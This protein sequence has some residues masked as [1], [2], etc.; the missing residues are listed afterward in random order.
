VRAS[1][2]DRHT[3]EQLVHVLQVDNGDL[4][5]RL[6]Q[7]EDHLAVQEEEL[8]QLDAAQRTRYI[9]VLRRMT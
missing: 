6:A 8:S 2:D 3:L 1:E 4:T 9:G 5:I 7:L